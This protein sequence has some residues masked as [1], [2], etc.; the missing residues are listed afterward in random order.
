[1]RHGLGL[2][3][4]RLCQLHRDD[5]SHPRPG[6]VRQSFP[7]TLQLH[8]VGRTDATI[9]DEPVAYYV[10][11]Q[12]EL[13]GIIGEPVQPMPIGIVLPKGE[14]ELVKAV[15]KALDELKADGTCDEI[16]EK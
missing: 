8:G 10:H 9:L 5:S 6:S 12:P 2:C 11:T 14:T 3:R 16:Y 7:E 1:M 4:W 15:R 13:G